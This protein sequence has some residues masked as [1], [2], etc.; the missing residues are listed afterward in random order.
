VREIDNLT[1][2]FDS[3]FDDDLNESRGD[4]ELCMGIRSEICREEEVV[5]AKRISYSDIKPKERKVRRKVESV[6]VPVI[7]EDETDT[8]NLRQESY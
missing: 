8:H 3:I 4:S 6:S 7:K 5:V 1:R 2:K